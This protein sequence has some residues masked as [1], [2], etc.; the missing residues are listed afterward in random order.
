MKVIKIF[1]K[2]VV[3][4]TALILCLLVVLPLAAC[5]ENRREQREIYAMD[6]IMTLTA[7][8][9]NAEAGLNAAES[10]ILAMDVMLDPELPTS[11]VYAIRPVTAAT[12]RREM[13]AL[14][15]FIFINSFM[16][17]LDL[18]A[19]RPACEGLRAVPRG[20]YGHCRRL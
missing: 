4:L 7:Y 13:T 1:S 2:R 5:G 11:T 9:K 19:I 8:G 6:T 18:S 17:T 20:I 10:V 14:V 12:S 3:R 15:F 16:Y